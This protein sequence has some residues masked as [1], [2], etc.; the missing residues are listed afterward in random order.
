MASSANFAI[1]G[2]SASVIATGAKHVVVQNLG[3]YAIYL[4]GSAVSE[5]NG[6][7]I[8]PDQGLFQVPI[9]LLTLENLYAIAAASA[10]EN[11]SDVRV[12][13]YTG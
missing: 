11:T 3:P 9:G 7:Q 12:L 2:N 10:E 5:S 6:L 13:S 4:G 1:N 8:N